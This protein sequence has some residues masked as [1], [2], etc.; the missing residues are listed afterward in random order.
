MR[1]EEVGFLGSDLAQR[2]FPSLELRASL[3]SRK[4]RCKSSD[5]S[6]CPGPGLGGHADLV[7]PVFNIV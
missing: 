4:L 2:I 3:Q 1:Q 7:F 5:D 6:L